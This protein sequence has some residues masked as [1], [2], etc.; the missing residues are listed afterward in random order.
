MSCVSKNFVW[1][2]EPNCAQGVIPTA[3]RSDDDECSAHGRGTATPSSIAEEMDVG[4]AEVRGAGGA[5]SVS[6][7]CRDYVGPDEPDCDAD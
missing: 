6:C 2:G 1:P 7:V 3:V 5:V 4:V